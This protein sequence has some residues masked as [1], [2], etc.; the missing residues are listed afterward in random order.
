MVAA[1]FPEA[2][3]I[4]NFLLQPWQLLVALLAGWVNHEQQ[5]AIEFL[6]TEVEVLGRNS[7][8]NASS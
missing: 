7:A 2:R 3:S 4:M 8:R 6:R 5:A 1:F